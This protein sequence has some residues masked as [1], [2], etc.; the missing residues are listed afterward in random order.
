MTATDTHTCP[1]GCRTQVP[2]ELLSCRS[3]WYRLPKPY[4][5]AVN[6]AHRKG[7]PAHRSAIAAALHW[8][9]RNPNPEAAP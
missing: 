5:D 9:Q 8:Y 2:H 6:T 1:G 7:G 3:C 4:R